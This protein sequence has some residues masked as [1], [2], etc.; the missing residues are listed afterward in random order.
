M[1]KYIS[2]TRPEQ[3][4][5]PEENLAIKR[6]AKLI[7]HALGFGKNEYSYYQA[8]MIKT[9]VIKNINPICPEISRYL[10][11]SHKNEHGREE[12]KSPGSLFDNAIRCLMMMSLRNEDPVLAQIIEKLK[13]D[14][15]TLNDH[16]KASIC[17]DP[18]KTLMQLKFIRDLLNPD[19]PYPLEGVSKVAFTSMGPEIGYNHAKSFHPEG[20]VDLKQLFEE[21]RQDPDLAESI[22]PD[23]NPICCPDFIN[24]GKRFTLAFKP[25]NERHIPYPDAL[26]LKVAQL[27][28]PESFDERTAI[29]IA[30]T[31]DAVIQFSKT[32]PLKKLAGNR[33]SP[34]EKRLYD[35]ET[36]FKI[37]VY[38]NFLHHIHREKYIP[39]LTLPTDIFDPSKQAAPCFYDKCL[40]EGRP[41]IFKVSLDALPDQF[42]PYGAL[43]ELVIQEL[44]EQACE[45]PSDEHPIMQHQLEEIEEAIRARDREDEALARRLQAEE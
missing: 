2:S 40:R 28:T 11:T 30:N 4:Y 43:L 19:E 45:R 5:T 34:V 18:K 42:K 37:L 44:P 6:A 41:P 16:I 29:A 35:S 21:C 23:D 17:S 31:Y 7:L 15:N 8:A 27:L 38:E 25:I 24:G 26:E 13:K 3:I 12:F 20:K 36:Q 1:K 10:Y 22:F 14:A 39:E 32:W 33:F 9:E